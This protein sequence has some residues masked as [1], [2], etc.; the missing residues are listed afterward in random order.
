MKSLGSC[1]P[2]GRLMSP[3]SPSMNHGGGASFHHCS[4]PSSN[5]PCV[6]R[7]FRSRGVPSRMLTEERPRRLPGR[8]EPFAPVPP[9]KRKPPRSGVNAGRFLL[10]NVSALQTA[11][12]RLGVGTDAGVAGTHHG[13]ATLRELQLLVAGGLQP[14]QA[15]TATDF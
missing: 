7:C 9:R 2:K 12:I 8:S 3:R 5:L 6:K 10:H 13:W 14:M 15:I 1:G 11:G 4:P